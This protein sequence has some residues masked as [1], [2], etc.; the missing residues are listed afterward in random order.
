[1][2]RFSVS[3]WTVAQNGVAYSDFWGYFQP[4]LEGMA[5]NCSADVQAVIGHVDK[6]FSGKNQKAIN[7]LLKV[8][9]MTELSNHL[10]DA[11]GARK[12]SFTLFASRS[13]RSCIVS[14]Q[15]VTTFGIGSR[16]P[17]LLVAVPSSS[18]AMLS[19]SRT[20]SA[21]RRRVGVLTTP[22]R[23]GAR[24]GPKLT[25]PI[26]SPSAPRC[27]SPLLTSALFTVCGDSD[28]V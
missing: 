4:I 14:A 11:A 27:R 24:S 23:L 3:P 20:E 7:S 12:W 15:C 1:M 28:V 21:R 25:T 19:K 8:F 2:R 18:S 16:F 26:V 22:F 17:P 6:V 9:N 10:D 13:A 5:P